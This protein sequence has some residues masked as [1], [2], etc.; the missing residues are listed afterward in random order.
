MVWQP[1]ADVFMFR[2][3][4]TQS[5]IYTRRGLLSKVTGIF[6]PLGLAAP[7]TIRE[8]IGI[9]RLTIAHWDEALEDQERDKR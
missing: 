5:V 3:G 1:E 6:D 2:I 9:Q 4:N 7:V 8:K